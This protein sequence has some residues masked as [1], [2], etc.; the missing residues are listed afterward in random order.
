MLLLLLL[1]L[2]LCGVMV[3]EVPLG[4]VGVGMA[5]WRERLHARFNF[6]RDADDADDAVTKSAAW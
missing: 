3:I 5:A 2:F 4:V 1:L 6:G